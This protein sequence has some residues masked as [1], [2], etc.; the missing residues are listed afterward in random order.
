MYEYACRIVRVVDGDTVDVD[1]DLGFNTWIHNERIRLN[2]ID[3]PE[4]R[5]SD[6]IEKFFGTIAK[7]EL[8]KKLPK[9]SFQTLRTIEVSSSEKYGRT[10]GEFIMGHININRWMVDNY[11]AV[12][13]TGQNKDQVILA[14]NENFK[15]IISREPELLPSLLKEAGVS[16]QRYIERLL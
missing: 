2:G 7:S 1:I 11:F 15:R 6:K 4:S 14:H 16:D 5:T 10:L 3:A 12:D 9:G 8:E 13:Y